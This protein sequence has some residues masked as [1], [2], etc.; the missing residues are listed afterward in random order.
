MTFRVSVLL[1]M[2]APMLS[3]APL[4]AQV[5]SVPPRVNPA[6]GCTGFGYN[7]TV[8]MRTVLPA[9]YLEVR[10]VANAG[11][12]EKAGLQVGDSVMAINREDVRTIAGLGRQWDRPAGTWYLL[13]VKRGN[14]VREV[15]LVS[16]TRHTAGD[17]GSRAPLCKPLPARAKGPSLGFTYGWKWSPPI[18]I[19]PDSEGKIHLPSY[20]RV[21]EI[22]SGSP[23]EQAGLRTGDIILSV[24]GR[25]GQDPPLLR[26][27]RPGTQV[28]LR[29]KRDDEEREVT[30]FVPPLRT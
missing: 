25:S 23:A 9:G 6:A 17:P 16:G 18:T 29:V 11:P 3:A 19:T 12:A 13:D 15:L 14:E 27:V 10:S 5:A 2:A 7:V 30:Y 21:K 1:A 24:N 20:P 22:R 28:V 8:D 26:D 4:N